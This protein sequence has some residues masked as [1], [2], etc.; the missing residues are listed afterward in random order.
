MAI[1]PGWPLAAQ[2]VGAE[3]WNCLMGIAGIGKPYIIRYLLD[4]LA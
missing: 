1:A 2:S 4:E 3:T